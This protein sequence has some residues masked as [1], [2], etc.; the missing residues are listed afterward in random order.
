[1]AKMML[2]MGGVVVLGVLL[3]LWLGIRAQ[4]ATTSALDKQLA[5]TPRTEGARRVELDEIATLPAPVARY[6]RLVLKEGQPLIRLARI[7]QSGVLRTDTTTE[8]WLPFEAEQVVTGVSPGFLWNAKVGMAPLL[9]VRVRDTYIAGQGGGQVS[10][11]S[12]I[13]IESAHG[14]SEMNSGALH[15]YL[16]EAVW[17]PTALLPSANLQWTAIDDAKALATLTDSGNKVSLEFRFNDAGEISGVYTGSRYGRFEGGFKQ[18]GW[19]GH[20]RNYAE[21]NGMRVPAEGEVGWYIGGAW[22]SVWKGK[23][24]DLKL[25]FIE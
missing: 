6:F 14:A 15:R 13:S 17:Y 5:Q 11:L 25:D 9:H 10:L 24:L 2:S 22:R 3:V 4:R 18:A 8:R 12:A 20:F 7:T 21:R 1:M 23:I 19:E 16:A